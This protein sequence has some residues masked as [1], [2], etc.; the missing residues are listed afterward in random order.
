M[1]TACC[2]C[3][4]L[5]LLLLVALL[6]VTATTAAA[7]AANAAANAAAAADAP[8]HSNTSPAQ[9]LSVAVRVTRAE[10]GGGQ[11]VSACAALTCHAFMKL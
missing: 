11:V 7:A 2:C 4:P 3:T 1:A 6:P 9:R 10:R 8:C 5:P